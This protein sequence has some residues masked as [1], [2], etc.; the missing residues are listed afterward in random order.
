MNG[1]EQGGKKILLAYHAL[2]RFAERKIPLEL[3]GKILC[4]GVKISDYE[5]GRIL[6]IYKSLGE[7]YSIV[8]EE[9]WEKF[10]IITAYRSSRWEM[11]MFERGKKH[12]RQK[13]H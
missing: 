9:D 13:T 5:P 11:E 7:F 8:Y 12:A 2:D 3:V 6:C 1:F 4:N 10:T